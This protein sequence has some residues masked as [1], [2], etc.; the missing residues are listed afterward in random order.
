MSF[1]KPETR[2]ETPC[3]HSK[4]CHNKRGNLSVCPF[5]CPR[6]KEIEMYSSM[7]PFDFTNTPKRFIKCD[8]TKCGQHSGRFCEYN[9]HRA[10]EASKYSSRLIPKR[11]IQCNE[12]HCI[13][14]KKRQM[15]GFFCEY[16][17]PRAKKEVTEQTYRT[18]HR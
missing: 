16:N 3:N 9:C 11:L 5:D 17:C 12:I 18:L 14:T 1:S 13:H 6:R 15:V 4:C 10:L 2:Y 7:T 8:K